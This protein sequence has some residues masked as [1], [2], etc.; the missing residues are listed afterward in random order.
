[1]RAAPARRPP[2]WR[3]GRRGARC[4]TPPRQPRTSH[5][6]PALAAQDGRRTGLRTPGR[7][8]RPGAAI[9]AVRPR[10]SRRSSSDHHAT[11]DVLIALVTL[12][13]GR[14]VEAGDVEAGDV[15]AGDVEAGDV[16]A[17]GDAGL[18]D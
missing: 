15:E 13:A 5:P 10:G 11:G 18:A 17:G 9:V 8:S 7:P 12:V 16:E 6:A 14:D 1:M 3:A 4:C 2:R